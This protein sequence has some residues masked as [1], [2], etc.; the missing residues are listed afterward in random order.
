MAKGKIIENLGSGQYQIEILQDRSGLDARVSSINAKIAKLNTQINTAPAERQP[1]LKLQIAALEKEKQQYNN[2]TNRVI[3]GWAADY[4]LE[5]SGIVGIANVPDEPGRYINIQPGGGVY[6]ESRDG[7]VFPILAVLPE[8]AFYNRALLPG[9]QRW[10]PQWR[11]GL[12]IAID[13]IKK[14]CSVALAPAYSSQQSLSINPGDYNNMTEYGQ[15]ET[16]PSGWE[17]FKERYPSHAITANDQ[18]GAKVKLSDSK[19]DQLRKVNASVNASHTYKHDKFNDT[20]NIMSKGATGDCEDFALTKMNELIKL[21]W[22]AKD[23]HLTGCVITKKDGTR[24]GHGVLQ[25]DTDQGTYTLDNRFGD[26]MLP[27]DP[28]IADY[29][30]TSRLDGGEWQN[31]A[32]GSILENVPVEYMDCNETA[33]TVG[34]WCLLSFNGKWETPKVIGFQSWPQPCPSLV[35][36]YVKP[37]SLTRAVG[38]YDFDLDQQLSITSKIYSGGATLAPTPITTDPDTGE[39]TYKDLLWATGGTGTGFSGLD[40]ALGDEVLLKGF[41]TKTGSLVRS[42][43]LKTVVSAQG[44]DPVPLKPNKLA[45]GY[46]G[47]WGI[48]DGGSYS[49]W[50]ISCHSLSNG[51]GRWTKTGTNSGTDIQYVDGIDI[52]GTRLFICS[53][54]AGLISWE[55]TT[56]GRIVPG[57]RKDKDTGDAM[58]DLK[59]YQNEIFVLCSELSS[60]NFWKGIKVFDLNLNEIRS[61]GINS[62]IAWNSDAM[63][64]KSGMVYISAGSTNGVYVYTIDGEFVREINFSQIINTIN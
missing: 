35:L 43:A 64:V 28:N 63:T 15:A 50:G 42:F 8:T 26:V 17:S 30:W 47:I 52:L 54:P 16:D 9:V 59:I 51:Y 6:N 40:W 27:G 36:N 38:L 24:V 4:E 37:A 55:V 49:F 7:D 18:T 56:D 44:V 46:G 10:K 25:V 14:T 34:D 3:L 22:K 13:S 2:I 11:Y 39:A 48:H 12:I 45:Y 41:D 57:S 31:I 53:R 20:W 58:R 61:F 62:N 33:F 32:S 21:G 29:S 60:G 5:L 23:L 1:L 19:L